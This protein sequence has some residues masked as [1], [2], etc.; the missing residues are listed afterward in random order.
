MPII[1]VSRVVDPESA[2]NFVLHDI[3]MH[4]VDLTALTQRLLQRSGSCIMSRI[5]P[6][7]IAGDR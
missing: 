7:F 4:L 1:R 2:T 3:H 6:G 5:K